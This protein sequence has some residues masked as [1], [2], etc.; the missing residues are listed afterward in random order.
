MRIRL[1]EKDC[2]SRPG[3]NAIVTV[4]DRHGK[5][6]SFRGSSWPNPF[7]PN[8]PY[9][10][11]L[12][13]AYPAIAEGEYPVEFRNDAHNGKPG[14]NINDNR[15]IPT[16]CPNPNRKGNPLLADHVDIHSGQNETWRGSA[17]CL[18]IH[19]S[20]YGQFCDLFRHGETGTLE[21]EREIKEVA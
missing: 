5:V 18:T 4:I 3:Y 1:L 9:D 15:D 12:S 14:L 16:I 2:W 10:I 11:K 19:P 20:E 13:D 7:K 21:L 6:Y 17:A 8:P